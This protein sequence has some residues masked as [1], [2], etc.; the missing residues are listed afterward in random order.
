M[1]AMSDL[2]LLRTFLS[3]YRAGSVSAGAHDVHLSQPAVTAHVRALESYVGEELFTRT[4]R[5]TEPTR[6]G[7]ELARRCHA[8][9]DALEE[10]LGALA[11]DEPI[12]NEV[13]IG[14]PSEIMG[15]WLL[16]RIV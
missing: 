13:W 9:L 14:G 4:P 16:P 8:H 1:P 5:G 10:L 3:V 2:G 11:A 12:A 6:A 15:E 7:V